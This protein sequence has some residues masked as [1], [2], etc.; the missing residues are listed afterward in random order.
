[1][2]QR[3]GGREGGREREREQCYSY[4]CTTPR[5][6]GVLYVKN[7]CSFKMEPVRLRTVRPF[8]MD[9]VCLADE[10]P[11]IDPQDTAKVEEHL[12]KKVEDLIKKACNESE[13]GKA[14]LVRL[15]VSYREISVKGETKKKSKPLER[16]ELS[17]PGL[18]DQC[19]NH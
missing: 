6:C 3:E 1:M 7:D 12:Q 9:A 18:Q 14:P 4:P 2:R 8:I 17:T 10:V 5:H 13:N 19:S 16:F 11:K 15:K